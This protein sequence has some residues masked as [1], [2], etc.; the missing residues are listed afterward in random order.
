MLIRFNTSI[1]GAGWCRN[2]GE[3]ADIEEAEAF[4]LIK[5]GIA[6]PEPE[7][8]PVETAK[9]PETNTETATVKTTP[10]SKPAAKAK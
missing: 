4:R 1:V 8:Q 10:A 7:P 2:P 3:V 9:A 6:Q 5:A